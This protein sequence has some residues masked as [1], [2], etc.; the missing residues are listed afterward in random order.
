MFDILI[1]NHMLL[2]VAGV[3][4][5]EIKSY[6][7]DLTSTESYKKLSD[8]WNTKY[9]KY[10]NL[11]KRIFSDVGDKK[12]SE[13]DLNRLIS[14][15]DRYESYANT[16][17]LKDEISKDWKKITITLQDII[18]FIEN[19]ENRIIYSEK[20]RQS[21]QSILDLCGPL[22]NLQDKLFECE[23][24]D[25]IL[26]NEYVI[27][28]KPKTVKG[29]V[30]WALSDNNGK[31]EKFGPNHIDPEHRITWCTSVYTADKNTWN[32][33]LGYYL[34]NLTTLFYVINRDE[35]KYGES[36]RKICIGVDDIQNKIIYDGLVTVNAF[37]D[38]IKKEQDIHRMFD[39]EDGKDILEAIFENRTDIVE[40]LIPKIYK[41][42]DLKTLFAARN[43]STSARAML[44]TF[45]LTNGGPL[46]N[47]EGLALCA[48][49]LLK[50]GIESRNDIE[51]IR[52]I[53]RSLFIRGHIEEP[54][55]FDNEKLDII[56]RLIKTKNY[57]II[58][59]IIDNINFIV[60]NVDPDVFDETIVPVLQV[61]VE[62]TN[63]NTFLVTVNEIVEKL[64]L[65]STSIAISKLQDLKQKLSTRT[66]TLDFL[67]LKAK[68]GSSND[69]DDLINKEIYKL[70]NSV[71]N[72][73]ILKNPN[74]FR[75]EKGLMLLDEL[76][77]KEKN[78][79]QVWTYFSSV[80]ENIMSNPGVSEY[81][82]FFEML[83]AHMTD[84]HIMHRL[85][86]NSQMELYVYFNNPD[87][88]KNYISAIYLL[89]KDNNSE[90][91]KEIK[92]EL[93]NYFDPSSFEIP[94]EE[95]DMSKFS[96]EAKK[97]LR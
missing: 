76:Y 92:N 56:S 60:Q 52:D 95:L 65:D 2:E 47:E 42:K 75:S 10:G 21:L 71:I 17:P 87:E 97:A 31:L 6:L 41:E 73:H 79:S 29:S 44:R 80:H 93:N 3:K 96:N 89:N 61:I 38:P 81:P 84:N 26:C 67:E 94:K 53:I 70:N 20:D 34:G 13:A 1:E 66:E 12:I 74:I 55:T 59:E 14:T 91:S 85:I 39:G 16:S 72:K 88:Y 49:M 33:F 27:V 22:D 90:E 69:L 77:F 5:K 83:Y 8:L 11:L 57:D 37:N 25:I 15:L 7:L 23:H 36:N 4:L 64:D 58:Y 19:Q 54:V 78:I 28:V 68:S 40:K 82:R 63:T 9:K 32:E 62:N 50:T 35:Y 46:A 48:D 18:D 30:A 86:T 43:K 51:F 24:Y 45:L